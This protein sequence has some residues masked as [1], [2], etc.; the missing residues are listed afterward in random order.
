MKEKIE[1]KL[2]D[3]VKELNDELM[4]T[5][6]EL[7][8]LQSHNNPEY[9]K[10]LQSKASLLEKQLS[11][12]KQVNKDIQAQFESAINSL[13]SVRNEALEIQL[14]QQIDNLQDLLRQKDS[15]LQ[16]MI[17]DKSRFENQCVTL[18][19][20]VTT[21]RNQVDLLH[22]SMKVSN[23]KVS[24]LCEHVEKK[25]REI[26]RVTQDNSTCNE[27]VIQLQV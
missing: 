26:Q 10:D 9:I 2:R 12:Q 19:E 5:Q 8:M 16:D 20:Q 3:E 13:N 18:Q 25:E 11:Q 1:E 21:L 7:A 15:S 23:E 22:D 6:H 17:A 27:H 14:Q 4:S 24:E